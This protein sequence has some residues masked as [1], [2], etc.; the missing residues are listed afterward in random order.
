MFQ[1]LQFKNMLSRFDVEAVSNQIEDVFRGSDRSGGDQS[2]IPG[3]CAGGAVS[4]L[5]FQKIRGNVLPLFAHP[6]GIRADRPLHGDEDSVV[7]IPCDMDTDMEAPV[8]AGVRD[9]RES[10]TVFHVRIE[11]SS[12]VICRE[13]EEKTHLT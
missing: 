11:R 13:Q 1:R 4:A 6:S 8:R 10:E 5:L 2:C 3:S 7:T 9:C 12:A